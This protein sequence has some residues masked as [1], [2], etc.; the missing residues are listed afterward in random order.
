MKKKA[1]AEKQ[2][3]AVIREM[4]LEEEDLLEKERQARR[5]EDLQVEAVNTEAND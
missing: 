4:V 1:E 5:V 3:Q 2:L